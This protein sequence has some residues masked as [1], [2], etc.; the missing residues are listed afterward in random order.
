MTRPRLT[1]A[2]Y[3]E[4]VRRD[5]RA[6]LAR[7]ITLVES[8]LTEDAGIAAAVLDALVPY[9]GGARRVGITGVPGV[10]KS[11]FI[12]ALGMHLIAE[13]DL[14]VAVL[15][16]DPSSPVSN[17]SILGDKTRMERLVLEER[18]YVRPSPAG[19]LLGGVARHTPEAMI[20]CE[21]AGF[22]VVLVETVGVGQSETAVRAMTDFFLL[23][24]LPG[25]GDE[26]QGI[27]RGIVE[28]VDAV[29]VNKAD[30]EQVAAAERAR[31]EYQA[32]LRLIAADGWRPPV[33]TCSALRGEGMAQIWDVVEQHRTESVAAGRFEARRRSQA[34]AWMHG[35][36]REGL[37][38]AF[39]ARPDVA[40]ALPGLEA[41]VAAGRTTPF[42]AARSL[43]AAA[44]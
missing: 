43:L 32:A 3:V 10:G 37:E 27:K 6:V 1:V 40:A 39:R 4:G 22:D 29:A 14:R 5:D 34:L 41:E 44:R 11:T 28:M 36:L 19:G 30:G 13:R 2:Q 9:A 26:L 21:A 8:R 25:A 31:T 23:L 20:L 18:G 7:A 16:V 38:A 15:S 35:L 24:L 33:M 42:A 12:D 17:G